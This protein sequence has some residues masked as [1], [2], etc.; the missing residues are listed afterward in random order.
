MGQSY[1]DLLAW[2]KAMNLV[3]EI[4][5]ATKSFPREE[6]YGLTSQLRRAAI[7]VPSNIAEGQARFSH[8]EF[9][10]FLSHARGSLVEIET[11]LLIAQ[12]IQYLKPDEAKRLLD[13]S[14]ELGRIL[15]GLI[16][17]IK[18]VA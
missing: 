8:R 5:G 17:S 13:S 7:S 10:Q 2:Q 14:A 15:N 4:Y 6:L 9:R 11:Q 18:S 16:A 12:S 1:K 3:M